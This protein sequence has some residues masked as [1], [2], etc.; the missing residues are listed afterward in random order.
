MKYQFDN[1][2]Y[3]YYE[4]IKK[5]QA[6]LQEEEFNLQRKNLERMRIDSETERQQFIELK[7]LQQH[8]YGIE[9]VLV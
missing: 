3:H 6:D 7:R 8:M 9:S 5:K 2:I 1:E 4:E